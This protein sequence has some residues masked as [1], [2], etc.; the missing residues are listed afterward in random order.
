MDVEKIAIVLIGCQFAFVIPLQFLYY[1]FY[2]PSQTNRECSTLLR[3]TDHLGNAAYIAA[4]P[5]TILRLPYA[6]IPYL[7]KTIIWFFIGPERE[8]Y[9]SYP[10]PQFI[11]TVGDWVNLLITSALLAAIT[12]RVDGV[13]ILIVLCLLAE[14]IRLAAEKGQMLFSA[15][16][17]MLPHRRIAKS[18]ARIEAPWRKKHFANYVRYY[19]LSNP[20]RID[21]IERVV[22]Q[23]AS[24]NQTA[25]ER[26][27]YF[28]G[29]E[30]V[31][32]T[33][34][35]WS[36]KVRNVAQG[37]V[38]IHQHWSNDPWLLIG[39]ALRRSSWLYDPRILPRPFYY[40]SQANVLMTLFVLQNARISPPY[41]IYQW[42]NQIKVAR[43]ELFHHIL[44]CFNVSI[45]QHVRADGSYDFQPLELS[46]V[47]KHLDS[48]RL[49][50]RV[51]WSADEAVSKILSEGVE[52]LPNT[53]EIADR[54]T[55]PYEYVDEV[56]YSRIEAA[57][58]TTV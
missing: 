43:N 56:L 40:W 12:T 16:W 7:L 19:Q 57:S 54:F 47:Y 38:Y 13:V 39:Q 37:T 3:S 23:Y 1:L 42:G 35:L 45:E 55:F 2:V 30:V 27:R 14:Y 11:R 28:H 48:G 33:H 49:N 41:G 20:E 34:P 29:F 44:K 21:Y 36:G 51:L 22:A 32:A 52:S 5:L 4:Y 17:Q 8:K 24:T 31:S 53:M 15:G 46:W 25:Q 10:L 18:L 9:W 6:L 26:L 58:S 50:V